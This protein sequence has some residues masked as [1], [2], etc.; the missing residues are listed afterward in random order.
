MYLTLLCLRPKGG[1]RRKLPKAALCNAM[2]PVAMLAFSSLRGSVCCD[3]DVR[4]GLAFCVSDGSSNLFHSYL[5]LLSLISFSCARAHARSLA[6]S[7]A[8]GQEKEPEM[9]KGKDAVDLG[10]AGF[11]QVGELL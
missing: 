11:R 5:L 6:R 9:P 7:L 8:I 1:R 2:H 3:L 4:V 10:R